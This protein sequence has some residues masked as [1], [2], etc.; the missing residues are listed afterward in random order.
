MNL[1]VPENLPTGLLIFHGSHFENL[2]EVVG[3]WLSP[4]VNMTC[5]AAITIIREQSCPSG[6]PA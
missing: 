2:V 6:E 5:N 4:C 1:P 3:H